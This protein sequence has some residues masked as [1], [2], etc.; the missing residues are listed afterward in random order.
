MIHK[1]VPVACSLPNPLI[2]YIYTHTFTAGLIWKVWAWFKLIFS[3]SIVRMIFL[4]S[5]NNNTRQRAHVVHNM[6]FFDWLFI[7][8]KICCSY[9][10]SYTTHFSIQN[11]TNARSKRSIFMTTSDLRSKQ[12]RICDVD[13]NSNKNIG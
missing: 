3:F 2:T 5:I 9:T 8:K 10:N 7:Q 6:I 13:K 4:N 1:L 11:R 12:T